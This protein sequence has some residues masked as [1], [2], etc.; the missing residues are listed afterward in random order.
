MAIILPWPHKNL[1]P[2][3]KRR[4]HWSKYQPHT[5]RAR[6]DAYLLTK[7]WLA[8][9]P[10]VRIDPDKPLALRVSFFPPD[11]RRR[12][13]D[14]VEGSM[15]AYFDGIAWALGIDDNLFRISYDHRGPGI[16]GRVEVEILA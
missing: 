10:D 16:P 6:N 4:L 13:R 7:G 1:T 8:G 14:N 11:R 2:N 9:H 3:A 15:K 12:D 5:K